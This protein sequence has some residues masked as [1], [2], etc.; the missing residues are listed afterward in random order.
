MAPPTRSATNG[1]FSVRDSRKSGYIS[2]HEFNE[3][4]VAAMMH[5]CLT[6]VPPPRPPAAL[7]MAQR[8]IAATAGMFGP[9]PA[10]PPAAPF[11]ASAVAA[12]PG[13]A[14]EPPVPA[15]MQVVST[16]YAEVVVGQQAARQ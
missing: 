6:D 12:G 14:D 13:S 8:A 1:L 16:D 11:A 9:A 3:F 4:A 15:G 2:R 10:A 5:N 7:V